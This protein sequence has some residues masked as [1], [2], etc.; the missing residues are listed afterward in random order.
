MQILVNAGNRVN[1][2]HGVARSP[3][4]SGCNVDSSECKTRK[5]GS[6]PEAVRH[7]VIEKF[8]KDARA[9]IGGLFVSPPP[10]ETQ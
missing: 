2:S 1:F 7:R 6:T 9:M 3:K 5:G 10:T 8:K 4:I